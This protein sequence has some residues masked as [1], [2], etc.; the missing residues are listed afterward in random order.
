MSSLINK[1]A[2]R[3]LALTLANDIH[4][5]LHLPDKTVD[6]DGRTWTFKNAKKQMD[7]KKYSQVS[8]IFLEHIN[9]MVR[10]N[11]EEYIKNM[12]TT[13]STIK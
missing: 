9:S 6:N 4:G 7:G 11:V 10:V 3:K 1:R 8:T 12:K 5:Q 13:G 2:V